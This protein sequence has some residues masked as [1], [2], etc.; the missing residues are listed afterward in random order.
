MGFVFHPIYFCVVPI[1]GAVITFFVV[2]LCS[3]AL[4]LSLGFFQS[5]LSTDGDGHD[6]PCFDTV[7]NVCANEGV[8]V[9][10]WW[11]IQVLEIIKWNASSVY[12]WTIIAQRVYGQ[13]VWGQTSYTVNYRG[14]ANIIS[15]KQRRWIEIKC[16]WWRQCQCHRHHS[17]CIAESVTIGIS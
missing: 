1:V 14:H 9:C 13:N 16:K 8:R 4:F 7:S 12:L 17:H 3:F 2:F 11:P 10:V 5:A 15:F 6:L